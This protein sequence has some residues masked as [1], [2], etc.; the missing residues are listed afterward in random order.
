MQRGAEQWPM[1]AH[2]NVVAVQRAGWWDGVPFLAREYVASGTLAARLTGKPYP[3][4]SGARPG[5]AVGGNRELS[6]STGAVHGNL[7]PS[8][9]MLAADGI[10]RLVD[11]RL[12]AG[13]SLN[14]VSADD[15]DAT[16]LGYLAPEV[17]RDPAAE[18]RF[19][20]DIYGLGLILYELLT[21]QLPFAGRNAQETLEAP[22]PPSRINS[23]VTPQLEWFCLQC[24]AKNPWKRH[25][26]AYN[27]Q[28]RLRHFR[29]RAGRQTLKRPLLAQQ[30][31]FR[32]ATAY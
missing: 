17:L 12:T 7:K 9:V 2:P 29:E 18:P 20:T 3:L 1:L 28:T 11:F 32:R 4:T 16:G 19:Y 31:F 26:H 15:S 6:P 10:P 5:R 21:G 13:L 27:V 23:K 25:E 24:L 14:P 22:A 8:N 30:Q